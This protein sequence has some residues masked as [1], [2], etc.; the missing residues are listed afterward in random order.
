MTVTKDSLNYALSSLDDKISSV[1]KKKELQ[2]HILEK[3]MQVP[4]YDEVP[5]ILE[6]IRAL[7]IKT[8]ILSN[9]TSQTLHK[10]AQFAHIDHLLDEILSVELV[11]KYK[12]HPE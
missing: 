8:V 2:D 7:S 3:Y 1:E 11:Q 4:V 6:S 10:Q 12:P 5:E 9:G